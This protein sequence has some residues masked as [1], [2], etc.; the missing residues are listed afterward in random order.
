MQLADVHHALISPDDDCRSQMRWWWFGPDITSDD[1]DRELAAMVDAGVGGVEVAFVYPLRPGSPDYLS[2]EPLAVLRHAAERA[3]YLGLRFHITLGSGWSFGGP[4]IGAQHAALGLAWERRAVLP[5]AG[6][7]T[8]LPPGQPDETLVAAA[9][10]P[11]DLTD[12]V[13][14][15][16][17][18]TVTDGVVEV[19]DGRGPRVVILGVVRPTGQVVKRAAAGADGPVLDHYSREATRA[20]LDHVGGAILDAVPAELIE[21][22]FCDSLE[23]Y[24]S[25][26]TSDLPDEFARRRG[27]ALDGILHLL[28]LDTREPR[29]ESPDAADLARTRTLKADFTRTLSELYEERFVA[30]CRRWCGER[31]IPFRIQ[32]YG[33]PPARV[34]SYRFADRYEGEGWGWTTLTATRW[35]S[36]AAH[37]DGVRI[38]SCEAWTWVHSPSFRATPLDLRGEAHEHLLS[39]VNE[40]IGHGWPHSPAEA[41][42]RGWFFYAAGAL[43]DRNPWWPAM[44][45]VMRELQRLSAV[46]RLGRPQRDVLVLAP[47]DD[48]AQRLG[49]GGDGSQDV[50][51]FKA[52][53]AQLPGGVIRAIRTSGRDY[54]LFDDTMLDRLDPRDAP[55]VVVAGAS[56]VSR[57]TETW[58]DEVRASGGAVLTVESPGTGGTPVAANRLAEA[59]DEHCGRPSLLSRMHDDIGIVRRSGDTTDVSV[60]VNTGPSTQPFEWLSDGRRVRTEFWSP[61]TGT[62]VAPIVIAPYEAVVVVETDDESPDAQDP[63]ATVDGSGSRTETPG[64]CVGLDDGWSVTFPGARPE[65]VTLPHRWE[66]DPAWKSHSGGATYAIDFEVDAA[67]LADD[68]PILLDLGCSVAFDADRIAQNVRPQS[69]RVHVDQP[70]GEIAEVAVNGRAAGVLWAP[71]YRLD[72]TRLLREGP[73]TLHLVVHNTGANALAGDPDPDRLARSVLDDYGR[74]FEF[75]DLDRAMDDTRSGLFG[76]VRLVVGD[77]SSGL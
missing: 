29:D 76:P 35:A 23:V 55:V 67:L 52:T 63:D 59:L 41:P 66:D 27:Y 22:L 20:H 73:N 72:V 37:I 50:D 65:P 32:G 51:L 26:W 7:L 77:G 70:V 3:R 62:R 15:I 12:P 64:R 25:N 68:R 46:L 61:D 49:Q 57:A 11:G 54:D 42:G 75:Q 40:L 10:M 2:A 34:G 6:R 28:T 19:P 1:V 33:V 45:S 36:S 5:G 39:G 13:R 43:D 17:P 9:L 4:H 53:R 47:Y 31:G 58:L 16:V 48:A 56:S 38:V 30:E 24:G 14:D 8:I 44:P 21:S 74:R 71:P 18:L 69:Y 60:V